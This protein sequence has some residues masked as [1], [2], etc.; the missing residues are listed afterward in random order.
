MPD[1]FYRPQQQLER[2]LLHQANS[3]PWAGRPRAQELQVRIHFRRPQKPAGAT[4]GVR[5]E[6]PR[7]G[8]VL[9]QGPARQAD[10]VSLRGA[11]Q[12]GLQGAQAQEAPRIAARQAN[13]TFNPL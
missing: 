5:Q 12:K 7:Q 3:V 8:L 11:P 2:G 10:G 6:G 9:V 4:W 13:L 1:S